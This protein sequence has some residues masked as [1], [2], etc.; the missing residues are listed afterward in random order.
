MPPTGGTATVEFTS[1]RLGV[2]GASARQPAAWGNICDRESA[3][4]LGVR[5]SILVRWLIFFFIATHLQLH[6]DTNILIPS[7]R[8]ARRASHMRKIRE[9]RVCACVARQIDPAIA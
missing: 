5:A 6:L 4:K 9:D 3:G 7:A 2:L 1:A 8:Y